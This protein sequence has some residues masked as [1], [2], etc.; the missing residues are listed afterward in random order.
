MFV[1]EFMNLILTIICLIYFFIL[2][3]RF[4][5]LLA[6]DDTNQL[7]EKILFDQDSSFNFDP[8]SMTKEKRKR[9]EEKVL[10]VL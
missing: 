6:N 2:I 8:A 5:E 7:V 1:P 9:L 10:D 4:N 3:I